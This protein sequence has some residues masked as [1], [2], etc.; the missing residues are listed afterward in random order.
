MLVAAGVPEHKRPY[1]YAS[2]HGG[3]AECWQWQDLQLL[4]DERHMACI[5]VLMYCCVSNVIQYLRSR[6]AA[7]GGAIHKRAYGEPCLLFLVPLSV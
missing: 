1:R 2:K 6:H 5:D 7:L 4:C 3:D